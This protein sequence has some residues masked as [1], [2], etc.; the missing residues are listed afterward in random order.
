M[1]EKSLEKKKSPAE[2][3]LQPVSLLIKKEAEKRRNCPK[4]LRKHP[5]S[6]GNEKGGLVEEP[7]T[8]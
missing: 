5:L 8:R 4:R 2:K 3:A 1:G 6:A 7:S